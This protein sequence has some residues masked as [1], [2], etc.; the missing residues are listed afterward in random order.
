MPITLGIVIR[1]KPLVLKAQK[2][3]SCG[4]DSHRPLDFS[5]S[6]VSPR[7]PGTRSFSVVAGVSHR[8]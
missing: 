8:T 2:R 7:C 5:L 4:F 3:S 1:T 6:G